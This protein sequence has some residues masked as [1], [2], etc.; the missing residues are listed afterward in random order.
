VGHGRQ[1]TDDDRWVLDRVLARSIAAA[2]GD[3]DV[4]GLMMR[5]SLARGERH[6]GAD[7]DLH[8]LVVDGAGRRA[9]VDVVDGLMVETAYWDEA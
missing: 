3:A 4:V 8:A 9:Q 6:T 2:R 7:V 5:G 1:T